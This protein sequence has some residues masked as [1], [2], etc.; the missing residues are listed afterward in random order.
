MGKKKRTVGIS[1]KTT[2]EAGR[3]RSNAVVMEDAEARN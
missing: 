2:P 1:R 3:S